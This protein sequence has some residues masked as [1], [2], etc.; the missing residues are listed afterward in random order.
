QATQAAKEAHAA[1]AMQAARAAQDA[2]DVQTAKLAQAEQAAKEIQMARAAR[3]ARV[4]Q[5]AQLAEAAKVA[6]AA[7]VAREAQ[8]AKLAQAGQAAKE[9]QAAKVAQS[10]KE[11]QASRVALITP[12]AQE[13]Q[14]AQPAVTV[15]LARP[16][17]A[18]AQTPTIEPSGRLNLADAQP[19]LNQLIQ[20]MQAGRGDELLRGLDRSVR[21][22]GGAADLVN[23]YNLLVGG[24]RAVRLGPVKL[25][26][27]SSADQL[28]V[29]G[30]VH[31]VLQDQ[32]QPP[33]VRELHL[34]ALFVQRDGKVVMTELSS[35]GARP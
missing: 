35:G 31:L 17:A 18:P 14:L 4:A 26:G 34:R 25:H 2:K 29:D 7:K 24:S 30:V 3:S 33:P 19:V 21:N 22:S 9:A 11:A 27:R 23:A 13:V 1:K 32:G 5:E 28:A 20:S 16:L 15:A 6:Q 8:A 10:A 12:A